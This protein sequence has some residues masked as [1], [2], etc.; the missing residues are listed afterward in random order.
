MR[1]LMLKIQEKEIIK[2]KK[3]MRK[4][5]FIMKEIG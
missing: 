1:V 3:I 4:K 2:L 5:I